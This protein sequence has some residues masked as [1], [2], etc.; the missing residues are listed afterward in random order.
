MYKKPTTKPAYLKKKK[1]FKKK[2]Y[3]KPAYKTKYSKR[4]T[5]GSAGRGY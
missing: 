2:P 1:T 5:G 4:Y 3:K